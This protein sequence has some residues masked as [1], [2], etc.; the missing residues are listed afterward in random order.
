MPKVD[1]GYEYSFDKIHMH[2]N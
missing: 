1:L 2:V